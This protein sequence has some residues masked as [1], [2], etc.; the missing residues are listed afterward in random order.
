MKVLALIAALATLS[1]LAQAEEVV[2]LTATETKP[3]NAQYRVERMNLQFDDPG[4]AGVDEG[5]III[6]LKGQNG[7]ARTCTYSSTTSPTATTLLNG[8]NKA[9]LSSIY[10]NN[11]TTG[12]LKQRIFH[13]L[14]IM[15]EGV[16]VCGVTIAGTQAGTVP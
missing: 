15:G 13:R 3:S 6:Q 7:E 5:Q 12:S 16:T 9:D 1:V 10:N 4:T 2:N 11:A 8:L 14:A